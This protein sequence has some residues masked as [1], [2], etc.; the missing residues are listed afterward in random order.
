MLA[1]YPS[2]GGSPAGVLARHLQGLL[3]NGDP[4]WDPPDPK[5]ISALTPA[6]FRALWEPMLR[7]GPIE[8]QVFGD[9]P[10]AKAIAEAAATIGALA[11]RNAITAPAAPMSVQ[12]HNM[13][14]IVRLPARSDT[15]DATAI[16]W[17]T[18]GGAAQDT[19]SHQ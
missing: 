12:K 16:T 4:R 2:L 7:Q 19:N 9:I 11:P 5:T 3:H 15:Q 6:S 14:P 13:S 17:R 8:E 10:A 18:D 1:G